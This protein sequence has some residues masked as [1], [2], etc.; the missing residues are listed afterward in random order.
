MNNAFHFEITTPEHRL[1]DE[2]VRQVTLPTQEG[3]LTILA[4]HQALAAIV[5]PGELRIIREDGTE[6]LFVVSRGFLEVQQNRVAV[7]SDTAERLEE[8]DE[9]RAEEARKRAEQIMKEK[10]VSQETLAE[11]E[12]LLERN[13]ARLRIVRK[14]RTR[15]RPHLN[16]E[17]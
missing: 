6:H 5:I 4:H 1:L 3:E 17:S 9:A 13:L 10:R 8:I 14:H 15:H 12:A 16:N 11:T 7:L 2:Q